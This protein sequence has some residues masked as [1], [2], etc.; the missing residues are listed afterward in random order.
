MLPLLAQVPS[1]S[2]GWTVVLALS[3]LVSLGLSSISFVRQLSG[4]SGE[5]QVEPTQLAALAD[6]IDT[7]ADKIDGINREIGEVRCDTHARVHSLEGQ[8][9]GIHTRIG[10]ISRELAATVSRVDAVERN[11]DRRHA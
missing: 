2:E 3:V 8:T 10:G 7:L 5:R 9:E 6:K 4:K 11:C 1:G